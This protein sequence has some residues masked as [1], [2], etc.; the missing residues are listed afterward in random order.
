MSYNKSNPVENGESHDSSI[1]PIPTDL[2]FLNHGSFGSCPRP[3]LEYQAELRDRMEKQPVLFF[4]N[5]LENLIDQ[6]RDELSRFVGC[7]IEDLVFVVY[8]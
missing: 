8:I 5:D 6:A 3:V 1:W 7:R 4:V 2:A